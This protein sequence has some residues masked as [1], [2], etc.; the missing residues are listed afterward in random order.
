MTDAWGNV[1]PST[2]IKFGFTGSINTAPQTI[3]VSNKPYLF[4]GS[5]QEP[6]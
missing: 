6:G 2:K 1:V 3:S 5:A 4:S